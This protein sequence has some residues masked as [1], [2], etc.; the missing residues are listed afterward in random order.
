MAVALSEKYVIDN[1]GIVR[2]LKFALKD[3]RT[4]SISG[5]ISFC[6]RFLFW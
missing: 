2:I 6:K 5:R 1:G 4:C 3:L